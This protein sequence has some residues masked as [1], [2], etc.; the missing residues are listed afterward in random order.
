M[1]VPDLSQIDLTNAKDIECDECGS[2]GFKQ[3]LML[4]KMSALISP[5]GQETMIPIQ[6]FACER[7]SH[8]NKEFLEADLTMT[9]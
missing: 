8:I 4:K 1:S 9:R 7:C 2:R 6:A 3:T 5:N